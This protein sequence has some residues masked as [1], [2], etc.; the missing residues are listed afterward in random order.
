MTREPRQNCTAVITS[1]AFCAH[2]SSGGKKQIAQV[3]PYAT[4]PSNA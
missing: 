4:L 2:L 3:A 1:V